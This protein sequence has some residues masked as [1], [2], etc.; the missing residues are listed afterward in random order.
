VK[1]ADKTMKKTQR[2]EKRLAAARE[3]CREV[4]ETYKKEIELER[5]RMN[6]SR[7]GF[8]RTCCQQNIDQLKAEKDA[9]EMEVVG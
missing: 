2:Y 4:M 9:I 1:G 3:D 5:M 7:N 6:T 8:V